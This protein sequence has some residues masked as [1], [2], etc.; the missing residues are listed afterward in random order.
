MQSIPEHDWKVFK[1]RYELAAERMKRAIQLIT[2]EEFQK[3]S[4]ET[5]N[6]IDAIINM[7]F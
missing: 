4:D 7:Q 6:Y 3:F 2:D 1:P 5:K